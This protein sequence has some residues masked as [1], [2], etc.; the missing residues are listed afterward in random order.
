MGKVLYKGLSEQGLYLI[1]FVLPSLLKATR[2]AYTNSTQ[3]ASS[4]QSTSA[5]FV[6][7]ICSQSLWH[8]RFGHPTKEVVNSMLNKSKLPSVSSNASA[9]V[10]LPFNSSS[11]SVF[12]S[13]SFVLLHHR[14]GEKAWST[15]TDRRRQGLGFA[16]ARRG[17]AGT[18][19]GSRRS[20]RERRRRWRH[21]VEAATVSSN[22]GERS[23]QR[24]RDSREG[25]DGSCKRR[26]GGLGSSRSV[27]PVELDGRSDDERGREIDGGVGD[28]G[29]DRLGSDP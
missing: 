14:N 20:G 24:G 22:T 13:F 23:R 19:D 29:V 5:A 2:P 28:G 12:R 6:G 17:D 9:P 15:G 8:K 11:S 3:S 18:G 27:M 1:P 7:R 26:Y 4:T 25:S 21:K 10:F 16:T